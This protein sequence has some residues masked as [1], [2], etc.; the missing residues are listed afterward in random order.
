MTEKILFQQ[1]ISGKFENSHEILSDLLDCD[2]FDSKIFGNLALQLFA[3]ERYQLAALIFRRWTE[4]DSTNPEPWSNL[5]LA[6][7]RYGDLEGAKEAL[8]K[9]LS[10]DSSYPAALNNLAGVYQ[11]LGEFENQLETAA[12]AVEIQ[13]DSATAL[14]NLG[15]ALLD[16]GNMMPKKRSKEVFRSTPNTS[17]LHLILPGLPQIKVEITKQSISLKPPSR[18]RSRKFNTIVT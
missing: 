12:R 8:L 13:P 1:V 3:A 6:L 5:G 11:F 17:K 2:D 14:N 18:G 7:S 16:N 15:T 10:I 9:A 4:S